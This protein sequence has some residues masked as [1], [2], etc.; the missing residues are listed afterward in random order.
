MVIHEGLFLIHLEGNAICQQTHEVGAEASQ[1]HRGVLVD[2]RLLSRLAAQ[3]HASPRPRA[4][5]QFL[6]ALQLKAGA[7]SAFCSAICKCCP[8]P[9]DLAELSLSTRTAPRAWCRAPR[10]GG[11]GRG[12]E[13]RE[14][15][16]N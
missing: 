7:A 9:P 16:K 4:D 3:G 15:E 6:P 10:T 2:T 5:S 14:R 12:G 11:G 1:A 8:G 13:R